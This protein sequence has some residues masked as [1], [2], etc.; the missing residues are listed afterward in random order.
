MRSERRPGIS[1]TLRNRSWST[2]V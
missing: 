1:T 2:S